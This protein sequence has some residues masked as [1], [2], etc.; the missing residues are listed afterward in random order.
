M[1]DIRPTTIYRA[2]LCAVY[3]TVVGESRGVTPLYVINQTPDG[4]T[5][6]LHT[7]K[8]LPPK[9]QA[10]DLYVLMDTILAWLV[11]QSNTDVV[12]IRLVTP[13][14]DHR[15]LRADRVRGTLAWRMTAE[16]V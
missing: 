15:G 9:P 11:T 12:S 1:F 6:M 5:C 8:I 16:K 10:K 7:L 14:P 3:S 13:D 2:A 4:D